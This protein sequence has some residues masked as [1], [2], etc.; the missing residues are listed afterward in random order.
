MAVPYTIDDRLAHLEAAQRGLAHPCV[1]LR[2]SGAAEQVSA[3]SRSMSKVLGGPPAL[4]G[5]LQHDVFA[6]MR[7]DGYGPPNPHPLPFENVTGDVIVSRSTVK[8]S[9]GIPRPAPY[10]IEEHTR[11]LQQLHH[12]MTLQQQ[13]AERPAAYAPPGGAPA[14]VSPTTQVGGADA[15]SEEGETIDTFLM[16]KLQ[17]LQL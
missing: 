2:A 14:R 12:Q 1:A 11:W 3:D 16:E 13:A 7:E 4:L 15:A 9:T 17:L 8:D 6:W 10:T 5:L